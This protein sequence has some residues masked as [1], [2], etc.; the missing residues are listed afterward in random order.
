MN[1][2]HSCHTHNTHIH[3]HSH[4]HTQFAT[5]WRAHNGDIVTYCTHKN[6]LTHTLT[7]TQFATLWR[8]DNGVIV[9]YCTVCILLDVIQATT[10]TQRVEQ[11][12]WRQS[13]SPR[14]LPLRVPP[15]HRIYCFGRHPG[16][17]RNTAHWTRMMT[18]EHV[19]PALWTTEGCEFWPF[20]SHTIC[21][22]MTST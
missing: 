3:T 6:T 12:W 13:M 19:P 5:L 11:E 4:T 10:E 18:S 17:D 14:P 8:A 1:F 7:H 22:P 15:L 2:G 21:N 20:M 9:T 16:H